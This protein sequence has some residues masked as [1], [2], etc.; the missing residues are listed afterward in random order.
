MII[1]GCQGVE[2]R[3][4]QRDENEFA[5]LMMLWEGSGSVGVKSEGFCIFLEECGWY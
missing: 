2:R 3:K 4:K 5:E 1:R